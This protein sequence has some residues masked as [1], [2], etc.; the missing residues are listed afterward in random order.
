MIREAPENLL[1]I[2][3]SLERWENDEE[4]TG[5]PKWSSKSWLER[6]GAHAPKTRNWQWWS[7]VAQ[8]C[9]T[10]WDPMDCSRP[11]FLCRW[12]SPGKNTGVGCHFLLQGI[13]PTQGLKGLHL[14]PCLLKALHLPLFFLPPFILSYFLLYSIKSWQ[15]AYSL[16]SLI[17]TTMAQK[18]YWYTPG[19]GVGG[20][21]GTGQSFSLGKWKIQ[22]MDDGSGQT[23]WMYVVPL[24][25]IVTMLKRVCFM[26][27]DFYHN[28]KHFLKKQTNE[29]TTMAHLTLCPLQV[30]PHFSISFWRRTSWKTCRSFLC[31]SPIFSWT[32]LQSDFC[33][34][35]STCTCC[36]D[37]FSVLILG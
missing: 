5:R 14:T 16:I 18:V 12:D 34:S 31:L 21:L 26:L 6:F 23:M 9:P 3:S 35:H 36:Q 25:Y 8:L 28:R 10:L 4:T 29:A 24:N 27:C 33:L 19:A 11:G 2:S 1:R 20:G 15:Y 17:I 7:L 30:L 32:M 37:Q 22:E 13:V